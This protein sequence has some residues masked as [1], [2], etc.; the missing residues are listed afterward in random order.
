MYILVIYYSNY[1]NWVIGTLNLFLNLTLTHVDTLLP[2][3]FLDKYTLSSTKVHA[4]KNKVQR[5][6]LHIN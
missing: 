2:S 5:K 6:F 3:T 1:N 4:L